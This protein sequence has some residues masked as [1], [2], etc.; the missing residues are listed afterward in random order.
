MLQI[1]GSFAQ[2]F[3]S[4]LHATQKMA[5]DDPTACERAGACCCSVLQYTAH[6]LIFAFFASPT[7]VVRSNVMNL[8]C[9]TRPNTVTSMSPFT[10]YIYLYIMS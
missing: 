2:Y 10:Q 1:P 7:Q 5:S 9:Y 3:A 4:G 8:I 6:D